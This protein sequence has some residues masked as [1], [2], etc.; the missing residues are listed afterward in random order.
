MELTSHQARTGKEVAPGS[1]TYG[2]V[3]GH[4]DG[5]AV[6]VVDTDVLINAARGD[7]DALAC[8]HAIEQHSSP[9]ASAVTRMELI[10]GCR[11]R[12]DLRAME[13]FLHRFQ[14]IELNE[15]ISRTAV[16][17]LR[18]YRLSHGLLIADALI[19]ATAITEGLPLISKNQR[20]F[21][22]IAGLD[23]RPYPH[24]FVT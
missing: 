5:A 8:I 23:L 6:V 11:N 17:L 20:D 21:R 1:E 10:V 3:N 7:G 18:R 13:R 4:R 19:A 15:D 14:V 9:V 12:A 2:R 22:F 24:P 16:R